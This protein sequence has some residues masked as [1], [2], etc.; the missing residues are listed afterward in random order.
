M[1]ARSQSFYDVRWTGGSISY[2]GFLIFYSDNDAIMR[3]RYLDR[4]GKYKV[5]EYKCT[6]KQGETEDHIRYYFLGGQDARVVYGPTD[7]GYSA[8]NFLFYNVNSEGHFDKLYTYDGNDLKSDDLASHLKEATWRKMDP[9]ELTADYVYNYFDK[10]ERYYTILTTLGNPHYVSPRTDVT[11]HLIIM[12]NTRDNSIGRGCEVDRRALKIEFENI[13]SALN[14]PI[15]E[16]IYSEQDFTKTNLLNAINDLHPGSN[17]IV[18]FYYRGHGF[19]W[20][21][22]Q[23]SWPQ[24]SLNYSE[25]QA[26]ESFP[27]ENVYTSIVQKGARLNLIFGDLCNSN[28]GL[29]YREVSDQSATAFQ[30]AFYPDMQKLHKLFIDSKGNLLST[31]AR[32]TEVSWV[33]PY[34]GG[35][36]TSS[37]LES[38]HKEVSAMSGNGDWDELVNSTIDKAFYKSTTGCGTCS[39]QHGIK[40]VSIN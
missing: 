25:F 20:N 9:S 14:I 5:A 18:V 8:D 10:T 28:I 4:N 39:A 21:D 2:Y 11:L 24:M 30:S 37:F 32:P 31:A 7:Y 19:R 40:Y 35:F 23:S 36:Y 22:Q 6:G 3:I 33:N 38:L 29:N 1:A 34:D 26:K 12:A 15:D 17:D 13:A 27:I 16:K